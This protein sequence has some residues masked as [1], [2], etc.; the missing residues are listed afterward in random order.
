MDDFL[1]DTMNSMSDYVNNYLDTANMELDFGM[2]PVISK[3]WLA[4]TKGSS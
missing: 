4:A 1:I 3:T 2:P